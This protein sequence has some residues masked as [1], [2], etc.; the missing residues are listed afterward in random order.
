VLNK[1]T[2]VLPNVAWKFREVLDCGSPAAFGS[3]V[4]RPKSAGGPAQSKTLTLYLGSQ[5]HSLA[6]EIFKPL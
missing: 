4:L 2:A 6:T 1:T 5:I 3:P